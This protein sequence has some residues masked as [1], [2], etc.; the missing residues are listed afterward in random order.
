MGGVGKGDEQGRLSRGRDLGQGGGAGTGQHEVREGVG[1]GHILDEILDDHP[2]L[3]RVL[4]IGGQGLGHA[5]LD[6]L[7][8]R[9]AGLEAHG[10]AGGEQ[11]G[12]DVD[13]GVVYRPGPLAAA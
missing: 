3:P 1:L 10:D 6:A 5:G 4:G 7:E 11:P 2:A 13:D 9:P 8:I 12:Q